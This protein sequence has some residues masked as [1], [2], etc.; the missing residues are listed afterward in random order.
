MNNCSFKFVVFVHDCKWCKFDFSVKKSAKNVMINK[1]FTNFQNY[2]NEKLLK[3]FETLF[4]FHSE[5]YFNTVKRQIKKKSFF[6]QVV[7]VWRWKNESFICVYFVH[8]VC[9]NVYVC[10]GGILMHRY[11]HCEILIHLSWSHQ[12]LL[13]IWDNHSKPDVLRDNYFFV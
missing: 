7:H 4:F 8:C 12:K 3:L 13:H 5:N 6:H 11:K 2:Q 10:L 9:H 1:I